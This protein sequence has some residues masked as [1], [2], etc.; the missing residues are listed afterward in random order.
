MN[1]NLV[2]P[3]YGVE[4]PEDFDRIP[5]ISMSDEFMQ[6]QA[7][8]TR[9]ILK[10][11]DPG[12]FSLGTLHGIAAS[13]IHPFETGGMEYMKARK[14]VLNALRKN[15]KPVLAAFDRIT[16]GMCQLAKTYI[17]LGTDGVYYAALGGE[18]E[19]LTDEEH[20]RW[21]MPYDLKIM[22][23]IKD[24]GGYC[25][26][27]ICKD[28]LNMDRYRTYGDL[29]DVVNWGVYEAPYSLKEGRELF[30]GTCIMGGLKNRS[31]ALI[32]GSREEL[33][34]S[35]KNAAEEAGRTGFILGADCTLPTEIPYERIRMA[36]EAV[37]TL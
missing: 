31:G 12:A 8:L 29:A 16:D 11:S 35:V 34:Q 3:V 19:L 14:F 4:T 36:V 10:Q 6:K 22:R 24:A 9:E 5:K 17:E 21:F 2:P 33:Y 20:E 30:S 7:E 37:R 18:K 28:G 13:S 23:A 25:F 32:T 26:L 1:E 15:E 27:H